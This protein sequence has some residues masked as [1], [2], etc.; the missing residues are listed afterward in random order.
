MLQGVSDKSD[1]SD[2]SD[3]PA[4]KQ[5]ALS[6]CQLTAHKPYTAPTE[7]QL[8]DSGGCKTD[9]AQNPAIK[10]PASFICKKNLSA[11]AIHHTGAIV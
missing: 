6:G 10:L 9:G 2:E 11:V 8:N 3:L 7:R 1:K 5:R 4:D